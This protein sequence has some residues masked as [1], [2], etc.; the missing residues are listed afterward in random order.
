MIYVLLLEKDKFYVGHTNRTDGE[1]FK[2]HFAGCGS[3]W[4]QLY[5]PVQVIEWREGTLMDENKVT[6]EYMEKYGWW[7]VRGGSFCN[8]EMTK[9]PKALMPELPKQINAHVPNQFIIKQPHKQSTR[10][11]PKHILQQAPKQA[12]NVQIQ[13]Y[14]KV[15]KNGRWFT[16]K[17]NNDDQC[18][19]DISDDD[20]SDDDIS[21]DDNYSS[22]CYKCGR[23]GHY[24]QNC[25]ASKHIDGHYI[26]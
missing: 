23:N 12:S 21:D 13:R 8:V 10:Q 22:L 6:L 25:Y 5:K 19:D 15:C 11:I 2:E 16:I 24:V 17:I 1:R 9:P 26:T 7:N 20:T 14:R 4:T 18:D 3:K